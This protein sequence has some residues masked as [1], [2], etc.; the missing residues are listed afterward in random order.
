MKIAISGT[1]CVGKSTLIDAFLMGHPDFTHEPEPYEALQEEYGES[2][3]AD[4]S[5]EDFQRQ[6]EYNV[7]RIGEY[8]PSELVIFERCPAD[9]LAYIFALD[10]LGRDRV[11]SGVLKG[12]LEMAREAIHH[13]DVIVFLPANGANIDLS[14]TEDLELRNSVDARLESILLAD[15]LRLFNSSQ[16]L[17]L[18]ASGNTRQRLQT[19]EAALG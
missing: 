11:A 5:A 16:P 4:P 17:V 6:L 18:E 1:H 19:L 2:F 12:S 3:A 10:E 13:L 9:Y 7:R 8:A 14:E 15:E